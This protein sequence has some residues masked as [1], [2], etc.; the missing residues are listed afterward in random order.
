MHHGEI[1]IYNKS[2]DRFLII[3][4]EKV[5][6]N[7]KFEHRSP[8]NTEQVIGIFQKGNEESANA[9]VAAAKKAYNHSS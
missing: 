2:H 7:E 3:D 9:A 5:F 4:G 6:T 8:I 1:V